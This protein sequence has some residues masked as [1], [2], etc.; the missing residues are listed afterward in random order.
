MDC[1]LP[2]DVLALRDETR[3]LVDREL[4]PLGAQIEDAQALPEPA[5]ARLRAMGYFGITIPEA[6]GGLGLGHLA[7]VVIQQELARAH[8]AFNMIIS[9]NNGIGAQG[10]V[11][12]GTEAQRLRWLPALA[13]GES[14]AAFALSEPGAGSDAQAIRTRADRRPGGWALTGTKHFI[15]R[16]DVAGVF[17]VMAL[18]DP[19]RRAQGGITAFVVEP[20]D[21]GFRVARAL[22]SMGTDVV[23]QVEL[24]FE[25]CVLPDDRVLGEVGWGFRIAMRVLNGGRLSLAA[26]CLGMAEE[27]LALSVAYARERQQFGRPIGEFQ[28]V[29]HMLAD[30]A[31]E[32]VLCRSMLY[33]Q[34]WRA[35]RGEEH[36]R[37]TSML[38]L[39]ASEMLG[40]VVDRAVQVHGAMGYMRGTTVEL[41]YR[42]ARM[43]R[44]VEGTSEIQRL[45]IA[46]S[47]L[48][49]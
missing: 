13:R 24:V 6:Y 12:E 5:L 38:K 41:F 19:A 21:A 42:E 29:Q 31:T 23:K 11:V 15:S 49:S 33:E 2:A 36:R 18:T 35:D 22:P 30:M 37:E 7:H 44:I 39:Y 4:R 47:L 16:G 10:I 48:D 43:M 26:R 25:D 9:G 28:A 46:R 8:P 34:A 14:V 3:K 27:C 20:D 17:T 40:R 45:I 32:T 1:D